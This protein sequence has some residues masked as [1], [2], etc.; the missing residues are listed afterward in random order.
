MSFSTILV[1]LFFISYDK[2]LFFYSVFVQNY[3]KK[4]KMHKTC[5]ASSPNNIFETIYVYSPMKLFFSTGSL[6]VNG[7]VVYSSP[8]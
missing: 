1:F 3:K 5:Y 6:T 4:K 2:T 7:I 8:L